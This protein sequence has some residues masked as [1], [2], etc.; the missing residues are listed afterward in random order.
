MQITLYIHVHISLHMSCALAVFLNYLCDQYQF[1]IYS[2]SYVYHKYY[3]VSQL[4][5]AGC[6]FHFQVVTHGQS[7]PTQMQA[8]LSCLAADLLLPCK[9]VKDNK[10]CS[11]VL[12]H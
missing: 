2:A 9:E 10:I 6:T 4:T 8:V 5:T 12:V 7:G 1:A 11:V 3:T